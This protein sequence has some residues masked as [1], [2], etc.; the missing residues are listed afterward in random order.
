M[1]KREG[2]EGIEEI[3]KIFNQAWMEMHCPF[4]TLKIADKDGSKS[5][6]I[7]SI[8]NG[9]VYIKP[10]IV[11]KGTSQVDLLYLVWRDA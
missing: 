9:E 1:I 2:I 8:E 6:N 5:S 7:L 10:D 4:V 3:I 11:S